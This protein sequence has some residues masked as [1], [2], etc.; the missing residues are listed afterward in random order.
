M[1]D[2]YLYQS[3]ARLNLA[4]PMLTD[5]SYDS[6]A[7]TNE[8]VGWVEPIFVPLRSL[9]G[10]TNFYILAIVFFN[11]LCLYAAKALFMH[12]LPILYKVD[13]ASQAL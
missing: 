7:Y 5:N 11:V 10:F 1:A 9:M 4:P 12:I 6:S 2:A 13:G 3:F 8:K